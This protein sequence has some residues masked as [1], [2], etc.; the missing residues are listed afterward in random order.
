MLNWELIT[1]YVAGVFA[2]MAIRRVML[3]DWWR[4]FVSAG[5]VLGVAGVASAQQGPSPMVVTLSTPLERSDYSGVTL[6]GASPVRAE[7]WRMT[8]SLAAPDAT[9]GIPNNSVSMAGNSVPAQIV[10]GVFVCSWT[11]GRKRFLVNTVAYFEEYAT[12]HVEY[13]LGAAFA[14]ITFP[15][16]TELEV[17][18]REQSATLSW[19]HAFDTTINLAGGDGNGSIYSGALF[20]ATLLTIQTGFSTGV[21]G[22]VTIAPPT[23]A[24]V[25]AP[26]ITPAGVFEITGALEDMLE[27]VQEYPTTDMPTTLKGWVNEWKVVYQNVI[28]YIDEGSSLD[29]FVEL[30]N[31]LILK[32]LPTEFGFGGESAPT[33]TVDFTKIIDQFQLIKVKMLAPGGI[34][35]KLANLFRATLVL[36]LFWWGLF[37]FYYIAQRAFGTVAHVVIV[38][39]R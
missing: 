19:S 39:D 20:H 6:Y 10:D 35:P 8:P 9:S 32:E 38:G 36:L 28:T 30:K 3:G 5:L 14:T 25:S 27:Q 22:T 23:T 21:Q 34:I 13:V 2:L 18:L 16:G 1:Y 37:R 11:V 15:T 29:F 12:V 4:H 33:F 17:P 26:L 24:P 7:Y 31:Y